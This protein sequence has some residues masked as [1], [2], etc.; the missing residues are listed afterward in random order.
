MPR[1]LVDSTKGFMSE[2]VYELDRTHQSRP[3]YGGR[4]RRKFFHGKWALSRK[5]AAR[6]LVYPTKGA[7]SEV[8]SETSWPAVVTRAVSAKDTFVDTLRQAP[9]TLV[10]NSSLTLP[11]RQSLMVKRERP[12]I[13]WRLAISSS[14]LMANLVAICCRKEHSELD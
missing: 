8:V 11:S 14:S 3:K 12:V 9:A 4:F 1:V 10:K 13:A 2:V 5:V 6:D 7:L